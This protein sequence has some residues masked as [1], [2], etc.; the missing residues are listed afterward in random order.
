MSIFNF[1]KT[2]EVV[3]KAL[4]PGEKVEQ[5]VEGKSCIKTSAGIEV[6]NSGIA[7]TNKNR[8]IVVTNPTFEKGKTETF[9]VGAIHDQKLSKEKDD[10][11]FCSPSGTYKLKRIPSDPDPKKLMDD[12]SD[13]QKKLKEPNVDITVK[14]GSSVR[15]NC[16]K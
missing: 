6:V 11:S 8:L 15:V 3:E 16:G 2:K 1:K 10:I 9:S 13:R 14:S 7:T 4:D 5:I 12:L